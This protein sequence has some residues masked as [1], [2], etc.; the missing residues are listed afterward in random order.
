MV[1]LVFLNN[2]FTLFSYLSM[3]TCSSELISLNLV[4]SETISWSLFSYSV[5]S[6]MTMP[7]PLSGRLI[8]IVSSSLRDYRDVRMPHDIS[9]LVEFLMCEY[10][11][12]AFSL[13]DFEVLTSYNNSTDFL[14]AESLLIRRLKPCPFPTLH[15]IILTR[16]E[17]SPFRFNFTF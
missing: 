3:V 10:D 9:S 2:L 8:T 16:Y 1:L 12:L 7:F 15:T 11:F 17:C 6:R 4:V 14:T 13:T 5:L